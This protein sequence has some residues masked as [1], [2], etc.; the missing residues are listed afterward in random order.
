MAVTRQGNWL[1]QMRVDI[2]HIRAMESA[3]VHDFD[4]LAGNILA[5]NRSYVVRGFR[6]AFNGPTKA[7]NLQLIVAGSVIMHP[8][9]SEHGSIF[10]VPENRAP[11]PLNALNP[12]V[13][14][15]FI[16]N[17][18]NYVSL[19]LRRFADAST[20]DTVKFL[21]PDTG[22]ET[23]KTVPIGRILD[24]RLYIS[25]QNFAV[26][27]H[28]L[29]IAIV[30]TDAENHVTKA[31]DIQ[32]VRPMLYRLATGG[33]APNVRSTFGWASR[34]DIPEGVFSG[35]DKDLGSQKDWMDAVM[36][37][38]WEL[39]GGE[40]WFSATSDRDVKVAYG[41][42]VLPDNAN[43]FYWDQTNQKL[44]WRGI[45]ILFANS[46]ATYN[47]VADSDPDGIDFPDGYC[48]Y[49]DIKRD[50]EGAEVVPVAKPFDANLGQP[51]MPGSRFLLAWR[52][53]SG[54]LVKI[55]TRDREYEVGRSADVAS[56]NTAGVVKLYR[57]ANV[58]S[59]PRALVDSMLGTANGVATLDASQRV[60]QT[61]TAGHWTVNG[62]FGLT[63][64]VSSKLVPST[65]NVYDVGSPANRWRHGY[66]DG[67][68]SASNFTLS[69][70]RKKSLVIPARYYNILDG[71]GDPPETINASYN[72]HGLLTGV[73][74]VQLWLDTPSLP[75][76]AAV[77]AV[78]IRG[79]FYKFVERAGNSR[80]VFLTV[81]VYRTSGASESEVL[82]FSVGILNKD[83]SPQGTR[84][85]FHN[86]SHSAVG[87]PLNTS[88][89]DFL[90][91]NLLTPLVIGPN[92]L[93]VVVEQTF[94]GSVGIEN[95]WEV[96]LNSVLVEYE[97]TGTDNA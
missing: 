62:N 13:T 90:V 27:P 22:R 83:A 19:D 8:R 89:P 12:K 18:R 43:N 4:L 94:D 81:R 44:K 95:E 66:F 76:G 54:G 68:V 67:A 21:D 47:V 25:T 53:D 7:D 97:Y 78:G 23:A 85:F 31:E 32:D 33:D 39:G 72:S 86:A 65:T 30:T 51:T 1:P 10:S 48:L 96:T 52:K 93:R 26:S 80:G 64:N 20:A 82:N 16:A 42:D 45:T 55:Y 59:E 77:T 29:P 79:N 2:P 70:A 11:E 69:P 50:V 46:T 6:I 28:L 92:R 63:G 41:A 14:G 34:L 9:A 36:T 74:P 71:F 91:Y 5:G 88:W 84:Q 24:Y 57:A 17:S 40:N 61:A 3:V 38:L 56:V 87:Y 49:V 35:G 75:H 37:R 73:S 58:P 60:V 15:S